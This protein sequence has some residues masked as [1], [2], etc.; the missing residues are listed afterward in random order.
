[1]HVPTF[2]S[3]IFAASINRLVICT[4]CGKYLM[5]CLQK[6]SGWLKNLGFARSQTW[7]FPAYR[8]SAKRSPTGQALADGRQT[9][10]KTFPNFNCCLKFK[11][12]ISAIFHFFSW[13]LDFRWVQWI[14]WKWFSDEKFSPSY[15]WK[16]ITCVCLLCDF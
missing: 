5:C 15:Q 1:M 16:K 11:N 9:R 10:E 13:N 2:M 7:T 6:S 12:R 4:I 8:R 14:I 3:S